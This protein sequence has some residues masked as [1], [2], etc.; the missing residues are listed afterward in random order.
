[1]LKIN[2][3]MWGMRRSGGARVLFEVANRLVAKGHDV[4]FTSLG[5]NQAHL[6]FPLRTKVKYIEKTAP[7]VHQTYPHLLDSAFRRSTRWRVDRIRNLSLAIP[8]CDVNVATYC[9]TAFAVNR[10]GKGKPFYYVQ[11][12]EPFFFDDPYTRQMVEETYS[13]PMQ[14]VTV[15]SWL[16]KTI[17][18][19]YSKDAQ[20]ILNGVDRR[21]FFPRDIR[22]NGKTKRI[23]CIGRSIEWKGMNDMIQAMNIVHKGH[24]ST[25]LVIVTQDRAR[26]LGM[27]DTGFPYRIVRAPNDEDLAR[28]YSASDVFVNPSWYE[29]F[30]LT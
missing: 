28:E 22:N 6:W 16:R 21:I 26:R 12:Y 14:L 11:H 29:G 9:L 1:M 25:E 23:M 13:L 20:V 8:D 2:F 3:A 4:T 19:K 30:S 7:I 18:E 15:S 5:S 27:A 17:R 24:P 10:S